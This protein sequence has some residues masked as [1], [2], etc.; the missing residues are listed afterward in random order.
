[1]EIIKNIDPPKLGHARYQNKPD[2]IIHRF[3]NPIKGF[4]DRAEF[5]P[6]RLIAQ[7]MDHGLIVLVD[8]D[9]H[10]S[11]RPHESPA[12]HSYK[13]VGNRLITLIFSPLV[14]PSFYIMR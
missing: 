9:N 6:Q 3:Q 10:L 4:Q 5:R 14:F 8:Q 11:A 7:G 12:D 1:M 2:I 13:T